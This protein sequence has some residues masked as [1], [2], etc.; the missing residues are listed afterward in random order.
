MFAVDYILENEKSNSV[1]VYKDSKFE[2]VSI[3]YVNSG[4]YE[5]RQ[6]LLDLAKRLFN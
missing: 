2:F 4:K 3:E 6:E 5:I 1:I